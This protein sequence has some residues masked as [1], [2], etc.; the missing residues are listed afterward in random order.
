MPEAAVDEDGQL[1]ARK[2]NVW[3]AGQLTHDAVA[4]D[5]NP[6]ER[7]AESKLAG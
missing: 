4:A 7:T 3:S 2:Y 1:K 6:P 5:T